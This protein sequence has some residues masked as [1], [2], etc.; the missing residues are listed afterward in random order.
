MDKQKKEFQLVFKQAEKGLGYIP[1]TLYDLVKKP[2]I[3]GSYAL[4]SANIKGFSG[5]KVS[6]IIGLK[7]MLKN[8]RWIIR[9]KRES[10]FEVPPDIKNLVG[11]VASNASGCRYCQAHT[12]NSAHKNG[13]SIEKLQHVWEFQTSDL[14]SDQE[15]A[16][17][18]FALAA[19]STPNLVTPKHH[20]ELQ[21]HFTEKQ[22]VEIVAVV[23]MYGFL[24]RWNDSMAT[25]LEDEPANFAKEHLSKTWELGKH[26]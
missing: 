5:S 26:G 24:N 20:Q 18:E 7:L 19:G 10:Q 11:H 12:A 25:K 3:L 22:I 9:A 2:N 4:L 8:M 21:K 13:V 15:K 14:F 6:P 16:A 17:L 1:N 23:S